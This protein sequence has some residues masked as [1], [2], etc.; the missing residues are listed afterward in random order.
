MKDRQATPGSCAGHLQPRRKGMQLTSFRPS[1]GCTFP[2]AC[3]VC[4]IVSEEKGLAFCSPQQ[5][6]QVYAHRRAKKAR[7][8]GRSTR[9]WVESTLRSGEAKKG[10][11]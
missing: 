3:G 8:R 6:Q 4:R 9:Q 11:G 7:R 1:V 2:A 5:C 10:K